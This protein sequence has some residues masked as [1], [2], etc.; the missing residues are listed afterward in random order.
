MKYGGGGTP[1]AAANFDHHQQQQHHQRQQQQQQQQQRGGVIAG[2]TNNANNSNNGQMFVMD[3]QSSVIKTAPPCRANVSNSSSTNSAMMMDFSPKQEPIDLA[4]L[5]HPCLQDLSKMPTQLEHYYVASSKGGIGMPAGYGATAAGPAYYEYLNVGSAAY[6]TPTQPGPSGVAGGASAALL[7]PTAAAVV[8][9]QGTAGGQPHAA[10]PHQDWP[11]MSY[12]SVAAHAG[13]HQQHQQQLQ[14]VQQQQLNGYLDVV[15]EH[16]QQQQQQQ[17]QQ[18]LYCGGI[19]TGGGTA[20]GKAMD[21]VTAATLAV[22]AA[23]GGIG[24]VGA[25]GGG[26][27]SPVDSGIGTELSLLEHAKQLHEFFA[28]GCSL[29]SAAVLQLPQSVQAQQPSSASS[30]L[31]SVIHHQQQ[32][33]QQE[34]VAGVVQQQTQQQRRDHNNGRSGAGSSE[35]SHHRE[36]QHREQ[37]LPIVIP[38]LENPLGF[39]YALEA[40]ISTSIRKEDDRMTY[41]NK[42]QFYTVSL[43]YIPDLHCPLKGLT[44]RSQIMVVFREDKTFED[45]LRTWMLWHKRQHSHKQRIIEVDAKNSVGAIGGHFDELAYNAVQFCWN[46]AEQ[47][48]PKVSIA[49]QCLSTDFSTQKGVKGLPLHVQIDT[50]DDQIDSKTPFH[51]GYCQIKVFCDKGAERKLRDEDKRADKRRKSN[52]SSSAAACPDQQHSS[53]DNSGGSGAGGANCGAGGG[54]GRKKMDG[55]FHEPADRSQ[56]YHSADMERPAPLFVPGDDFFDT[57]SIGSYDA[58]SE[59]EPQPKRP[60]PSERIMIYVRKQG[61]EIFT[62]LHLVP[63][64]LGGLARAVSEKYN[65]DESKIEAFYKQCQ[66]GL[67]VKID[68]DMLRHY[69]NQDTFQIE[70]K[71]SEL[72]RHTFY[73]VTLIELLSVNNTIVHNT[74]NNCHNHHNHPHHH[75]NSHAHQSNGTNSSGTCGGAAAASSS[76][77]SSSCSNSSVDSAAEHQQ[78]QHLLNISTN[79]TSGGGAATPTIVAGPPPPPA[80]VVAAAAAVAQQNGTTTQQQQQQQQQLQNQRTPVW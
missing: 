34:L 11:Y 15:M 3:G 13:L 50:F 23:T 6:P 71:Q 76:S 69:T 18:R 79:G 4:P 80:A 56:F 20:N 27:L 30:A 59:L 53:T 41:V 21:A 5:T 52:N 60:R 67:T 2:N 62:P 17:Q 24:T 19:G 72:D 65:L 46:P 7:Q 36:S 64:S 9:L 14:A 78:Q 49:V 73:S 26:L 75:H 32:Q 43:D 57:A 40:P 12:S 22:N 25:G 37:S 29:A 28:P 61:E 58:L 74:S 33:Q 63:P 47:P 31:Q 45:E 55:D 48:G 1:T 44:V 51:R 10:A 54:G 77:A 38:K 68:D 66:K 16:Q 70:L 42:G 8:A 39:Q 35:S